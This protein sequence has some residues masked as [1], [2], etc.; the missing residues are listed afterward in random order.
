MAGSLLSS[1]A[2]LS[3]AHA[4]VGSSLMVMPLGVVMSLSL[5][6]S[7]RYILFIIMNPHVQTTVG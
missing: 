6:P 1:Q 2:Q 3:D 4:P 5:D 7:T